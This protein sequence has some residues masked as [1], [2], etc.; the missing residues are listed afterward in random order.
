MMYWCS[1]N[2][3]EMNNSLKFVVVCAADLR[4]LIEVDR[5]GCVKEKM[6]KKKQQKMK[7]ERKTKLTR[8]MEVM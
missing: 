5:D 4:N 7:K 3:H 2:S 6:K 1:N 8:K